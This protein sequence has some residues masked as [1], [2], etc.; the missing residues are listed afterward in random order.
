MHKMQSLIKDVITIIILRTK[1]ILNDVTT[2]MVL[3]IS[4][5]LFLFTLNNL[6]Y[7][8]FSQS[9]LPIGI[10]DEDN[11]QS[12][13]KLINDLRTIPSLK[14]IEQTEKELNDRLLDEMIFAIFIVENGYESNLQQGNVNNLITMHYL[15]DNKTVAVLSDIIAGEMMEEVCLYKS[16]EFYRSYQPQLK[17]H[18]FHQFEE[19]INELKNRST[20]NVFSFQMNFVNE[21]INVTDQVQFTNSILYQ[22]FMIGIVA[23]FLS[24][25]IM[26]LL[27]FSIR[28]KEFGILDKL[29]ISR[30]SRGAWRIGSYSTV[31]LFLGILVVILCYFID[32]KMQWEDNNKLQSLLLLFFSFVISS[33]VFFIILGKMIT[34]TTTYQIISTFY[35]LITSG[36]G[37]MSLIAGMYDGILVILTK[38]I[39]N[40]WFIQGFTDIILYGKTDGIIVKSHLVLLFMALIGILLLILIEML[41]RLIVRKKITNMR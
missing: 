2:K 39:P 28:D 11:S 17:K 33:S 25:L 32:L 18:T 40:S 12:S 41:S 36:M 13:M 22:Q 24:F 34:R 1:L 7:Q 27:S 38:I 26:I 37:F 3:V 35:I 31:I 10:I 14:L 30:M 29:K 8:S 19:Y 4:I 15:R 23:T 5:I 21:G 9:G 6:T 20:E 16:Y